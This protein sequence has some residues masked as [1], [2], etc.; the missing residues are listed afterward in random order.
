MEDLE[1]IIHEHPTTTF[2]Y[3]YEF[4]NS[5]GVKVRTPGFPDKKELHKHLTRTIKSLKKDYNVIIK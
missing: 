4:T 5:D 1:V 3:D 2:T